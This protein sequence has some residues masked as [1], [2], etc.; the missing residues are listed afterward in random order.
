MANIQLKF[1]LDELIRYNNSRQL[2]NQEKVELREIELSIKDT[3]YTTEIKNLFVP[4]LYL[5]SYLTS[6]LSKKIFDNKQRSPIHEYNSFAGFQYLY[7]PIL[8]TLLERFNY[9]HKRE[10]DL[11]RYISLEAE[12]TH[13]IEFQYFEEKIAKVFDFFVN[14]KLINC[15]F[16]P[17]IIPLDKPNKFC[18]FIGV[19]SKLDNDELNNVIGFRIFTNEGDMI[20]DFDW[21]KIKC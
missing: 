18:F 2:T 13:V 5:R 17:S 7:N 11:V 10:L 21:N 6:K 9:K 16:F 19:G 12:I 15:S 14:K 8:F 20:G 3:E 4:Q 1:R